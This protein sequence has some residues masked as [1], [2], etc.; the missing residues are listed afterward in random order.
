M[1]RLGLPV[2]LNMMLPAKVLNVM[3]SPYIGFLND[4]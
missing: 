2:T 4:V 3:E 1:A